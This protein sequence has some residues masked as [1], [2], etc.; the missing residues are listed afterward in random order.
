M[1]T[2]GL[3]AVAA[4]GTALST[5][6]NVVGVHAEGDPSVTVSEAVHH[7][8]SLPLRYLA[9]VAAPEAPRPPRVIQVRPIPL[10]P[11]LGPEQADG[12]LQSSAA[13]TVPTTDVLKF[14]GV[15][16]GDYGFTDTSAPP[17]T[18]GSVGATQ[19]V[20]QVNTS[21]GIFNKST[22]A[23]LL[24]VKATNSLWTGFGGGCETNSDGDGVVKYDRIANRWVIT[25][26]SVSTLPYL[27]CV[28]VSKTSDATGA[29]YRYAFS[30]GLNAFPDYPKIAVWPDAYYA[31]YNIFNGG[32]TFAG[33]K[34]CALNRTAMLA[35]VAASQQC[36]QI[37]PAYGAVLPADLDG[38][39]LPPAG[40]PNY[41]VSF[42]TNKLELWKL[43][44]N[45]LTPSLSKLTGPV[46]IPVAAFTAACGGGGTCI[47]QKGVT[48]Q[49]DSL[50]DRLMYRLAYRN[51]GTHESLVVNHSVTVGSATAV[52]WYELRSPG[53]VATVFQSGTYAPDSVS[54]WMASI[55]MDKVGDIAV[56]YSASSSA[57][58]PAIRY[59]G[60]LSTD[61][62][63][64]LA[65]EKVVKAGGG[66]QNGGLSRWGD[67]TA[68]AIDPV[69]DCTF[70]YTNE[71]LKMTGK[72]NWSTEVNS[73]KF[74]ACH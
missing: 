10:A 61:P 54:R 24:A 74:A 17:D 45:W 33:A 35:G 13:T 22:G 11:L 15:G 71:Y 66:S 51:F 72:F 69:D 73:F 12:A 8:V 7:D 53:I 36:F 55:A 26:F 68:L 2:G 44:I 4:L 3:F 31:T 34:L 67:Y 56:G 63:G 60:R 37:S 5:T 18:N 59:T 57:I 70:Y 41:L 58:Y 30:Y 50:A 52:R 64:V 1:R 9:H 29:Y 42:G 21:L 48:Q 65:A 27:E 47:P 32:V 46:A 19:Y 43:H 16:Q 39:T 62:V 25:Q 28:A 23:L 49:L 40:S 20:Q 38:A 6:V 14:A